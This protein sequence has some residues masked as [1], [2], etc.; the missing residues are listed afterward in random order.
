MVGWQRLVEQNDIFYWCRKLA[1][2]FSTQSDTIPNMHA[3][4]ACVSLVQ[5][6]RKVA[7][8]LQNVLELMST[9]VYTFLNHN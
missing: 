1:S 5:C 3:T 4:C 8:Y 2:A 9:S 6:A 7:V